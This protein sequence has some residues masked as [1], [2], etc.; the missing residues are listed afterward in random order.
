VTRADRLV[1]GTAALG[2]QYGVASTGQPSR[3]EAI[4]LLREAEAAGVLALD[5]AP[6][7][8]D[9]EELLGSAD[10][11][12]PVFTKLTPGVIPSESV[13]RSL[14]RLRRLFLD[15]VF[16][17]D[18]R[19]VESDPEGI[20]DKA[21]RLVGEAI[22]ALGASV[23]TPDEF[24]AALADPRIQAIQAPASVA[25]QRLVRSGLL[26]RAHSTGKRVYVRSVLLQGALTLAPD[27]LP[28][29]LEPLMPVLVRMRALAAAA[30]ISPI[31]L[32]VRYVRHLPGVTAVILGAESRRQF[33]SL[34]VWVTAPKLPHD[35][36]AEIET[37]ETPPTAAIDPRSWPR[38]GD[39]GA[40]P[41]ATVTRR[42][43]R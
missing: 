18:H 5:T 26:S 8:G 6:T 24:V 1:L 32:A 19:L 14:S 43:H 37:L 35:V 21:H 33:R 23:Y 7:Y 12:A 38:I 41:P 11:A 3:T 25:D 20:I 4:S 27:E 2:Q 10:I 36:L 28:P 13:A 34:V 17:H 29:H 31:E 15:V 39:A 30:Q 22:G 16:L 9:S 40:T 42:K